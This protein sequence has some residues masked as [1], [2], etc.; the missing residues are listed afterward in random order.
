MEDLVSVDVN[1]DGEN[2][3]EP[4]MFVLV[5]VSKK[6]RTRRRLMVLPI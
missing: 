6:E 5:V 1:V 2:A 4:P 3:K